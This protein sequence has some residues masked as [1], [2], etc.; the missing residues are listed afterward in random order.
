MEG[1]REIGKAGFWIRLK[2][3][4]LDAIIV[5]TPLTL[6]WILVAVFNMGTIYTAV[7]VPCVMYVIYG[8]LL[9][10]T[11]KG[12]TVG[13]KIAGLRI[14]K[15]DGSA[16]TLKTMFMRDIVA[17]FV[18]LFTLG[19]GFFISAAMVSV[20]RDKRSIHDVIAGTQ[21]IKVE[22]IGVNENILLK[23][24]ETGVGRGRG[25]FI[26]KEEGVNNQ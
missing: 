20:R 25:D 9:P 21:V 19:I 13:K 17:G 14:V 26:G 4:V 24:K 3:V 5:A 1:Y 16:P 2:G 7:A 23:Q 8:F 18:Y 6:F 12:I 22:K 11:G 15:M 10:V